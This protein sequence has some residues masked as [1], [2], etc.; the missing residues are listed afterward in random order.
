MRTK[1]KNKSIKSLFTEVG[2]CRDFGISPGRADPMSVCVT[3]ISLHTSISVLIH[4]YEYQ[5]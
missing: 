2:M 5:V 4:E 3:D 1:S